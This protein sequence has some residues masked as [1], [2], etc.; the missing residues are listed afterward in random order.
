MVIIPRLPIG[1]RN[2]NP[3][4]TY[5]IETSINLT[6]WTDETGVMVLVGSITDN[7][8]GT[9]TKTLRYNQDFTAVP[10]MFF[11]VKAVE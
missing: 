6:A 10:K 9:D 8:D 7:G 2:D 11:R 1:Y 4:I 5:T 3:A